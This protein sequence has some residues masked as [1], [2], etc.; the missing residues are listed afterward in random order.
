[1]KRLAALVGA[2]ALVAIASINQVSAKE[3]PKA[4]N[5]AQ[6]RGALVENA[7]TAEKQGSSKNEIK[8]LAGIRKKI[9]SEK[10]LSI[11]AQNIKILFSPTGMAVLRGPVDSV[12]EKERL[13]ELVKACPGVKTLKTE[14]SVAAKP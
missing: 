4:D 13:E 2:C 7:T 3:A 1:M 6:N 14:L 5:T 9:M 10:G 11:N 12:A 8:V